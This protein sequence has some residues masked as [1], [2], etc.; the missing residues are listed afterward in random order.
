MNNP[1]ISIII[2]TY[3]RAHLIGETLD[4]VLAQTY[5][6]WECI[7]VDDGSTDT[8]ESVVNYY[9]EKDSRFQY[10]K[11]PSAYKSGG[12]G[13]RNYGFDV[14]KGEYVNW[15]D[16]DDLMLP[17]ALQSKLN[18]FEEN[19]D[20]VVANSLNFDEEGTVS[21][22]YELNYDIPITAENF[23]SQTIGWITN[24]VLVRRKVIQ[25]PFNEEL[26]SGQEYNFFAR[27]IFITERGKYLKK[28]VSKR[29][30]HSGSI[31]T[32]L[33]VSKKKAL[34]LL[35]N[36]LCLW[37]DIQENANWK[38]KKR[39]LKRIIRFS[40]ETTSK[41]SLPK[42]FVTIETILFFSFQWQVFINYNCWFF[43]NLII[44]KGYF[45]INTAYKK[46]S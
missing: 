41:F 34:Q 12:N 24:D 1:L 15:F 25:I 8:T 46:L 40:S 32:Q 5:R 39:I 19:V 28:D 11:R 23:I 13:A 20:F 45:F 42:Y 10:Y 17:D 6:N 27:L 37:N 26:K 38:I 3:N 30:I 18:A 35:E 14:S 7:I 33:S 4:S 31:Q 36:E 2:P 16:S 21:R 22:P 29:R 43:S 9:V 44:G